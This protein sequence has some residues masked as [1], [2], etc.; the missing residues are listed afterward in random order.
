MPSEL[1]YQRTNWVFTFNNY[2]DEDLARLRDLGRSERIQYMING[3][4]VA[5]TTGTQHVQGFIQFKRSIRGHAVQRLISRRVRCHVE[6]MKEHST[7]EANV[8]YCKKDGAFLEY[9]ELIPSRS[10]QGKRNDWSDYIAWVTE[11]GRLPTKR[12]I[13]LFSPHLWS[14][15]RRACMD[16]A[17]ANLPPPSLVGHEVPREGWQARLAAL[18]NEEEHHPRHVE[19]IVDEVGNSGKSWFTRWALQNHFDKVQ[20]V[21][22]SAK[23][24]DVAYAIDESKSIFLFDIPRTQ[25]TYLQ[26]S[27]MEML[28]NRLV[29]SPKYESSLKVLNQTPLVIVFSN[30]EPDRAAMSTDRY[31]ITR[32]RQL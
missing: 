31:K 20:V 30:E 27:V 23:R 12:E 22:V 11:L 9:G 10:C 18:C 25:M 26:Y 2:N 16:I 32:I 24:D 17:E 13:I 29:F 28:K 1:D 14:R 6:R 19:F 4:E 7:P 21:P 5:P 8:T 15:Y 3:L